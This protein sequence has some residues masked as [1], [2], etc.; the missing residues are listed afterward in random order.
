MCNFLVCS[1]KE[2]F[3]KKEFALFIVIGIANTFNGTALA[4]VYSVFLQTNI[5]FV[6]GYI[7]GLVIAFY[8]NVFFVFNNKPGFA[9]FAKFSVSYIPSFIIQNILVI[10]FYNGLQWNRLIVFIL[11]AGVGVPITFVILKLFAFRK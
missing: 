6:L 3:L 9:K 8:L 5:A 4:L 10:V 11:A 7:T 2:T 1:F